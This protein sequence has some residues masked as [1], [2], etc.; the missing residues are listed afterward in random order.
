MN[1]KQ[2]V[3]FSLLKIREEVSPLPLVTAYFYKLVIINL[4]RTFLKIKLLPVLQPR[5]LSQ[6]HGSHSFFF[7]YFKIF[8]FNCNHVKIIY[9]Y[10]LKFKKFQTLYMKSSHTFVPK[11]FDF[12]I[13]KKLNYH[14]MFKWFVSSVFDIK[15]CLGIGVIICVTL[16]TL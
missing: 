13:R 7:F 11:L 10:D 9:S 12:I 5:N 2:E 1:L 8:Y 16:L 15:N 6:G 4:W 3:Q 14:V